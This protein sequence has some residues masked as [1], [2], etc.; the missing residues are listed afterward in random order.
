SAGTYTICAAAI[1]GDATK[2]TAKRTI[3]V[4]AEGS[5]F[6]TISK[7]ANNEIVLLEDDTG[8]IWHSVPLESGVKGG[9]GGVNNLD[10]ISIVVAPNCG[11]LNA[12]DYASS[13]ADKINNPTSTLNKDL[14]LGCI[15]GP[16]KICV[17][18]IK[19]VD[20]VPTIKS[21]AERSV[22]IIPLY[23][24]ASMSGNLIMETQK[25]YLA[26]ITGMA[27][28]PPVTGTVNVDLDF[29]PGALSAFGTG[30]SAKIKADGVQVG[31]CSGSTCANDV[32]V[33][34]TTKTV[35][36]VTT[37]RGHE[38]TKTINLQPV[39]DTTPPSLSVSAVGNDTSSPYET[40]RNQFNIIITSNEDISTTG[41]ASLTSGC[42]ISTSDMGWR[43]MG[44]QCRGGC[45][46]GYIDP[47]TRMN[48]RTYECPV[49]V[50]ADGQHERHISCTDTSL[51]ENSASN[52][53][54]VTFTKT[55][56]AVTLDHIEL[57]PKDPTISTSQTF[58][59]TLH[60]T[61]G[62]SRTI[63]PAE[64]TTGSTY[65]TCRVVD[66]RGHFQHVPAPV[67]AF[68]PGST[69]GTDTIEARVVEG[70]VTKTDTTTV[71]YV[72][73]CKLK[74]A[75]LSFSDENFNGKVDPGENVNILT[76]FEG[77]CTNVDTIQIDA[78]GDGCNI[79][80][81]GGDIA[82]ITKQLSLASTDT[83][84]YKSY[85]WN[86][87]SI[88]TA[89]EGAT[90]SGIA[91]ALWDGPYP[92]TSPQIG[93]TLLSVSGSFTFAGSI[94]NPCEDE[95]DG[96][97]PTGCD[98]AN[99]ACVAEDCCGDE[100]DEAY[101]TCSSSGIENWGQGCTSADKNC[102]SGA[103]DCIDPFYQT[104]ISSG[105]GHV[106]STSGS[107]T[108]MKAYCNSGRWEDC[109]GFISACGT[110]IC[111]LGAGVRSGETSAHGEYSS[112]DI[113]SSKAEC[114]GDD[115]NEY[116]ITSAGPQGFV[117]VARCCNSPTDCVD[118]DQKCRS[119]GSRSYGP[120]WTCGDNNRWVV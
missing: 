112:S 65:F 66:G 115:A 23:D 99:S 90:V 39:E 43:E 74:S 106:I 56:G 67:C 41:F 77:D 91:A 30:I 5:S 53:L 80:Y 119:R 20:N 34:A 38:F 81:S 63:G 75:H 113:S 40:T 114:C 89:C 110:G 27:A 18:G 103:T 58:T 37:F 117:S 16:H 36:I 70:G 54:D 51:N 25:A 46:H 118:V 19:V 48:S 31:T 73:P 10:Y 68:Y 1:H 14:T 64:T 13:A 52:N 104:C 100:P 44:L 8:N 26:G 87:P 108:D 94:E 55:S 98:G 72:K 76:T 60:Y 28:A 96:A 9:V 57:N 3:A 93:N 116:Y 120:P 47:C 102:C 4:A 15:S 69:S 7:P 49:T 88:P 95:V 21:S 50:S 59:V 83:T 61:D 105:T 107:G 35:Q 86:V 111:G 11:N 32:Q 2:Q 82:G 101:R 22:E 17:A 12:Y 79:E 109:D 78:G 33:P 84:F 71:T 62:T 92:G 42:G 45:P 6:I 29:N 85:S 97:R 24:C